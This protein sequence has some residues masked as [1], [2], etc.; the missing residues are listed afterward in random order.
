MKL[1]VEF[2]GD[3]FV[4]FAET[5]FSNYFQNLVTAAQDWPGWL[6]I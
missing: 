6:I 1:I 3:Y 2:C 5:T 4:D